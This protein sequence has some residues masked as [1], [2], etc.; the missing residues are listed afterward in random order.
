MSGAVAVCRRYRATVLPEGRPAERC[1][2]LGVSFARASSAA[3]TAAQEELA[4]ALPVPRVDCWPECHGHGDRTEPADPRL[5]EP[6]DG[7][8]RAR[9][10]PDQ[11]GRANESRNE[12]LAYRLGVQV[13]SEHRSGSGWTASHVHDRTEPAYVKF[14]LTT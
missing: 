13:Q 3:R 12:C 7:H 14:D 11:S 9:A 4:G 1:R 10:A 6:L 8:R 5:D 2:P